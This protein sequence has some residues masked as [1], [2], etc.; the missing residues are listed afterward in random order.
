VIFKPRYFGTDERID[1]YIQQNKP[2]FINPTVSTGCAKA[3]NAA[4]AC[5][6]YVMIIKKN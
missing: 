1:P 4:Y 3:N 6:N 5:L 2:E